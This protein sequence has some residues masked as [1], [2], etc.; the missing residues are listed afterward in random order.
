MS[1]FL[2]EDTTG[3]DTSPVCAKDTAKHSLILPPSIKECIFGISKKI[4]LFALEM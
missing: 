2:A 4:K 3:I 1:D